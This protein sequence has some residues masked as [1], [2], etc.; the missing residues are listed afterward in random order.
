[1]SN[2][3]YKL[4]I[5][6]DVPKILLPL[7]NKLIKMDGKRVRI[8]YTSTIKVETAFECNCESFVCPTNWIEIVDLNKTLLTDDWY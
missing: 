8:T 1:M 3:L 6:K 2:K 4:N 7:K 5:P